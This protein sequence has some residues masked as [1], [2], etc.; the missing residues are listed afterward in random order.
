MIT[1]D[2]AIGIILGANIGS[3][4]TGFIASFRLSRAARQAS[5]AQIK[6]DVTF[7]PQACEELHQ[8]GRHTFCT[9]SSAVKAFQDSDKLLAKQVCDMESE[10]DKLYW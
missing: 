9:F 8:L 10:F 1:L 5:M 4:V 3:C 2:R 6:N 7:S